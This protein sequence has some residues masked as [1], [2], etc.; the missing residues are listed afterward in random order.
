MYEVIDQRAVRDENGATH[1]ILEAIAALP[2]VRQ[3]CPFMPHEYAVLNRSPG[4]S[5]FAL[6]AMI[7]LSPRSYRAYFR[8]Y[9]SPN[10]YWEAPDG[11]R[12][13][14]TPFELNRC[15]PSTA[16]VRRVDHG[17]TPIADWDGPPWAPPEAAHLY[18]READ[19]KW[20]PRFTG[21]PFAPCKGCSRASR[22]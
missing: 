8:G 12:Y 17:A 21:T 16:E 14:R 13:W 2:W 5:W 1:D 9:Q 4:A 3:L 7:R 11:M 18:E 15:E 19:G 6:D 22:P 20:W 10:R